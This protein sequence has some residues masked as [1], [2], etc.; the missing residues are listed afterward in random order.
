M[1]ESLS[2][3]LRNKVYAELSEWSQELKKKDPEE[4]MDAAYE[5]AIKCELAEK[6][7]DAFL[8][9]REAEGLLQQRHPLQYIYECWAS[10]RPR[11]DNLLA[12][13]VY[14][15]GMNAKLTEKFKE[16]NRERRAQQR[17]G[18]EAAR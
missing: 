15:A 2:V 16:D 6:V 1:S 17:K 18:K 10:E 4:I 14:N 3:Q 5:L 7:T 9:P 8:S 13:T 12:D 11:F